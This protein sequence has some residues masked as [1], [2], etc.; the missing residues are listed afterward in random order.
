LHAF[1]LYSDPLTLP[2][3]GCGVTNSVCNSVINTQPLDFV[4]NLSCPAN[5]GTVDAIDFTVN[6][7][8]A[9]TFVLSTGN[10]NITFHFNSSPVTT[11]GVQTVH[12]PAGAFDCGMPNAE[13]NCTFCYAITPL[14][15]T[16][17]VPAVGGTFSPP[18][19]G[20]YSYNVI[21]NQNIDAASVSTSDLTV[22][23]IAGSVTA[24]SVS[25]NTAHFTVHFNSGGSVTMSIAAGAITAN[26]CNGNAAFSGNY[27]V[28]GCPSPDHYTIS[29]ASCSIVPGTTDIGN[30]GDDQVTTVSLPFPYTLYDQTYNSVNLSSNGN[31]QFTTTDTA[32]TNQCL[33]WT[34]HD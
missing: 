17:T 14:Q 26:T 34:T 16:S 8:Q 22:T 10:M 13:F 24:V 25:G 2:G 21:F 1:D 4:I 15:V 27:T 23:G 18:A 30:H 31:A 6:G 33:P 19:P 20:D 5:P 7:I 12:I 28:Q 32:F 29:Q 9:N 3:G 11:Q